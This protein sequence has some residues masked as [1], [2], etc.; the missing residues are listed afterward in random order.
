MHQLSWIL[1]ILRMSDVKKR[2]CLNSSCGAYNTTWASGEG[3]AAARYVC[4]TLGKLFT[5]LNFTSFNWNTRIIIQN[6]DGAKE[7]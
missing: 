5:I 1:I 3:K 4:V 2:D 7:H 6:L